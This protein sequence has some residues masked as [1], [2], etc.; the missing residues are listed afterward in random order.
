MKD[1]IFKE[2]FDW[3]NRFIKTYK[4]DDDTVN[5]MFLKGMLLGITLMCGFGFILEIIN[6]L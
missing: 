3:N 2:S 5:E 4:E 6:L 1:L